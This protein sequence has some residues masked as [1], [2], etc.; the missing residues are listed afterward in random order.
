MKRQTLFA[1]QQG[2]FRALQKHKSTHETK[3]HERSWPVTEETH[4]MAAWIFAG[5]RKSLKAS[6]EKAKQKGTIKSKGTGLAW[7]LSWFV[8][9]H[10]Q[11]LRT[12]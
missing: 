3:N 10:D 5:L 9:S 1:F 11:P 8:F 12:A 7:K 6:E 2:F 4:C